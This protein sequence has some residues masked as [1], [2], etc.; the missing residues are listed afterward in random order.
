MFK[1]L[2]YEKKDL[3]VNDFIKI[4]FTSTLSKPIFMRIGALKPIE[5]GK[6]VSVWGWYDFPLKRV[7]ERSKGCYQERM[8]WKG[9]DRITK[10]E[11]IQPTITN[12]LEDSD[13]E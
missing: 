6:D 5:E 3:K 7:Q 13:G 10:I 11:F 1:E 9:I 8:G 12:F 4:Y 2:P